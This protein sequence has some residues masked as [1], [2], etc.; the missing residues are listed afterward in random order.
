[1]TRWQ[2]THDKLPE[3]GNTVLAFWDA[4]GG[5]GSYGVA[6]FARPGLWHEPENDENDF[7]TPDYW[8]PLPPPPN[9]VKE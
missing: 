3:E 8:M 5:G 9:Q 2:K 6:L 4:V 7:R 1:M